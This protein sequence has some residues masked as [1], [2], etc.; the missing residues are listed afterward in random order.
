M[1]SLSRPIRVGFPRMHK[2][3]G[4]RRD[5]LPDLVALLADHGAAVAVEHGIGSG[6]GFRDEDYLAA[7]ARRVVDEPTAYAQDIVV[8]L[9]AP[10]GRYELLRRGAILV[11][12]LH[13][14]TRPARVRMLERLGIDAVS[15]DGVA[16]DAGRRL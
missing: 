3:A 9:R 2:E 10:E 6:M 7:G 1:A 16:D 12:M 4:E 5:V 13:F 8:V 15:L 14:P 11:S